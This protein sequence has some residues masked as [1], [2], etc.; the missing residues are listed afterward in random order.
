MNR[1][2]SPLLLSTAV[3]P[4]NEQADKRLQLADWRGRPLS[5]EMLEYARR[6]DTHFLLYI[7]DRLKVAAVLLPPPPPAMMTHAEP[8]RSSSRM[9]RRADE[10]LPFPPLSPPFLPCCSR[11]SCWQRQLRWS[12]SSEFP[13]RPSSGAPDSPLG[14]VLERSWK[15]CH[16]VPP[17]PSIPFYYMSGFRIMVGG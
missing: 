15:L 8:T 9:G 3:P 7:H 5:E 16:K 12:R 14:T 17:P 6:M 1:V 4:R 10:E 13:I 11:Q 2:G